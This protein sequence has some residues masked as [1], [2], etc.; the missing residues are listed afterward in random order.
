[1]KSTLAL[2]VFLGN[3]SLNQAINLTQPYGSAQ[4]DRDEA[5]G[6]PTLPVVEDNQKF[7]SSYIE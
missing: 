5:A 3:L 6:Y 2:A 1:M 4:E 7:V